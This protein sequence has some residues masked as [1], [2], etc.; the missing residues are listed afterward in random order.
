MA[1]ARN[2]ARRLGGVMAAASGGYYTSAQAS[3]G[4]HVASL[5]A[6]AR[7]RAAFWSDSGSSAADNE[8]RPPHIASFVGCTNQVSFIYIFPIKV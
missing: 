6:R 3:F 8:V 1:T 5:C 7:I 4:T 2:K